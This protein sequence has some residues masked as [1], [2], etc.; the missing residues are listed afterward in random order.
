M[1]RQYNMYNVQC[2]EGW[3][4]RI[5]LENMHN[6]PYVHV[7]EDDDVSSVASGSTNLTSLRGTS[8]ASTATMRKVCDA[9]TPISAR[10]HSAR[11]RSLARVPQRC[12]AQIDDLE[13]KLVEEK[14]RA[15]PCPCQARG[16]SLTRTAARGR[17]RVAVERQLKSLSEERAVTPTI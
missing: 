12:P 10:A 5:A 7:R 13:Q 14:R 17:K 16:R 1:S 9:P 15:N 11:A 6:I 4:Q 2:A 8:V 3:K